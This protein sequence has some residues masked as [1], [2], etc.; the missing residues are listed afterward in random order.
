MESIADK[1][2]YYFVSYAWKF[3]R[4]WPDTK[5]KL[6]KGIIPEVGMEDMWSFGDECIKI[7]PFVWISDRRTC[8]GNPSNSSVSLLYWCE[9][10]K[11][12]Y[13]VWLSTEHRNHF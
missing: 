13:N 12:D 2:K 11:E 10:T 1:E 6:E 9:I 3:G 4:E 5:K 8:Q 7:H